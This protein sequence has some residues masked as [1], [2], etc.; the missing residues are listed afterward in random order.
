VIVTFIG[1]ATML[2]TWSEEFTYNVR[3]ATKKTRRECGGRLK[4]DM[5]RKLSAVIAAM[6]STKEMMKSK[7]RPP[8]KIH[9]GKYYLCDWIIGNFPNDYE[10]LVYLEP[11]CGAASTLMNKNPSKEEAIN[12]LD[13][14]IVNML[15]VI[16]DQCDDF[17]TCLKK[18]KYT[19]DNFNLALQRKEFVDELDAAVNEFIVRRMSRGGLKKAFAWSN[20]KRGGKPGDEN[21]W[22]TIIRLLPAISKRLEAVYVFNKPALEVLSAFDAPNTLAYVDPPYLPDTRV[23]TQA[24]DF[25]MSADDHIDVADSLRNFKGKVVLSGYPSPLYNRLYKEWRCVKKKIPNHASQQKAKSMK[26]EC[27]WLNF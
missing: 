6:L 2:P 14:S 8:F 3:S 22:E 15:R 12:D 7:L 27:L 10:S 26:T 13:K 23:S 20:R 17:V 4:W 16:R 21:A 24:Y 1:T 11:F 25:E 19:K 5:D 9:G 18:I